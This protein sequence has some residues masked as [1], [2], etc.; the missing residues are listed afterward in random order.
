M[1]LSNVSSEDLLALADNVT[2]LKNLKDAIKEYEAYYMQ[3]NE[4]YARVINE[5]TD[6]ELKLKEVGL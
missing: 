5:I 3:V 2:R 4:D 1:D 6:L